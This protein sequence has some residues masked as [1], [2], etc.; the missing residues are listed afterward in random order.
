M[1]NCIPRPAIV[2]FKQAKV[3]L[4]AHA[5]IPSAQPPLTFRTWAD[6][7][8]SPATTWH[9]ATFNAPA[10]SPTAVLLDLGGLRKGLAFVNGIHVANYDVALASCNA[11][12]TMPVPGSAQSRTCTAAGQHLRQSSC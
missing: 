7:S 6:S 12:G 2:V 11:N 4:A 1:L 3:D 5:I 9:E 10:G 8:T